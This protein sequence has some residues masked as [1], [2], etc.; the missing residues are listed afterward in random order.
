MRLQINPFSYLLWA[1]LLL[2]IPVEWLMAASLAAI[3]HELCHI[4]MIL[5]LGVRITHMTLAPNRAEIHT[6]LLDTLQE[7]LCALA[8][9]VGSFSLVIFVHW[10]PKTA[11]CGVIQ[12]L[13]NLIPVYPLDGGRALRC[14]MELLRRK[15]PCKR[16]RFHV[17]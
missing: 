11:I 6:G 9:P 2:T 17:Q 4:G 14:C 16:K 15:K 7:L 8:G 12:G 13:F 5:C 3:F 10:M 1:L